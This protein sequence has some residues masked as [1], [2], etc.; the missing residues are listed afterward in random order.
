[1]AA[2]L[3]GTPAVAADLYIEDP[4]DPPVVLAGGWYLRGHLGM[5]NQ[6]LRRL[7]NSALMM[8]RC[9]SSSMAAASTAHRSGGSASVIGSTIGC[10]STASSNIAARPDFSALDRYDED[11]DGVWD[12]TNDYYGAKSEWLLVANAYVDIG[13]WNGIKPYIGAGIGASRN[14][15]SRYRDINV[16]NLGVASAGSDP[17]WNFAWAL[18]AGVAYQATD[19]LAID[20]GYSYV[21]LGNAR[22]GTIRSYD[23]NFSSPRCA[24]RTSPCTIS[25]S[26]CA[27]RFSSVSARVGECSWN[28]AVCPRDRWPSDHQPKDRQD[29]PESGKAENEPKPK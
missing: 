13:N 27:M 25:S 3:G 21:D 8:S 19:R 24:S 26:A 17:T 6:R 9:T 28:G 15:I 4:G 5:S 23:G 16:P 1:M 29:C 7:E 11:G 2:L 20:F 10:A 14:K 18:H 22:T 12:G